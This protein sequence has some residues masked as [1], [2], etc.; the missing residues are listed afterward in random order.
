MLFAVMGFI[1]LSMVLLG[2]VLIVLGR[3]MEVTEASLDRS[4]VR[5]ELFSLTN[6]SLRW[7]S[8]ELRE[9]RRP[10]AFATDDPLTEFDALRVFFSSEARSGTVAVYDLDYDPKRL[11]DVRDPLSVLTPCPFGYM[12]R[13][14]VDRPGWAP[15]TIEAVFLALPVCTPNDETVYVL[16]E[17]PLFWRE[18]RR[19]GQR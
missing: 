17:V 9:G 12:I 19:Q 18:L 2:G 6:A 5:S 16:E 14:I 1:F 7:L 8:Q 4:R 15:F 10:R 11:R 13:A 3:S